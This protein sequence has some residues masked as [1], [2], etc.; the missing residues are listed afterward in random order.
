MM[1]YQSICSLFLLMHCAA[2]SYS[3]H[4]LSRRLHVPLWNALQTNT[5]PLVAV[6]HQ[7]RVTD[8]AQFP[9]YTSTIQ[10]HGSAYTY[11]YTPGVLY[12]T[13]ENKI[14]IAQIIK[15]T[16]TACVYVY[17]GRSAIKTALRPMTH[18]IFIDSFAFTGGTY[19]INLSDKQFA[20]REDYYYYDSSGLHISAAGIKSQKIS[21]QVITPGIIQH[22][23]HSNSKP[24]KTVK[25]I[26]GPLQKAW[27]K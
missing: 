12:T 21:K 7:K 15:E 13:D 16:D 18:D 5:E 24:S 10:T 2:V 6:I 25:Q 17:I 11:R 14:Y 8:Y 4:D 23:L 22:Y 1:R 26:L 20:K 3:Q 9:D 27:Q 19:F